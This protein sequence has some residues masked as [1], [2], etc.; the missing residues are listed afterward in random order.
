MRGDTPGMLAQD[1]QS[2]QTSAGQVKRQAQTLRP[3]Q[4]KTPEA[5]PE[6]QSTYSLPHKAPQAPLR[7]P[8]AEDRLPK[9][10]KRPRGRP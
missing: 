6:A 9:P 1:P 3:Y 7:C 10:A 4:A 8:G 2:A 5:G